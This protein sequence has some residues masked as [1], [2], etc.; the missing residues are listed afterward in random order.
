MKI[1]P[2][3]A[4]FISVTCL[5]AILSCSG[6]GESDLTVEERD[7]LRAESLEP[8]GISLG[9]VIIWNTDTNADAYTDLL[10]FSTNG[11]TFAN[12]TTYEYTKSGEY[13]FVVTGVPGSESETRLPISLYSNIGDFGTGTVLGNRLRDLLHRDTADFTNDELTEI[14]NILN[15]SGAGLT[16]NTSDNEILIVNNLTW[17]H[18]VQS[19]RGDQISGTMGGTYILDASVYSI[20]FRRPTAEEQASLRFIDGDSDWMPAVNTSDFRT[21]DRIEEGFFRIELVNSVD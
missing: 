15:P 1:R 7:S 19:D 10:T 6:D 18:S 4:S 5:T 20:T 3:I 21:E 8:S 9:D 2:I 14:A 13:L 11:D 12:D 17:T 16:V